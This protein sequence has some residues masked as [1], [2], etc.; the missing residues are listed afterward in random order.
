[1]PVRRR[2]SQPQDRFTTVT[3]DPLAQL[4]PRRIT[5]RVLGCSIP[6]VMRLERAGLLEVVK[7]DP[8]TPNSMTYHKRAQ[9][10]RLARGAAA[11]AD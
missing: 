11:D 7:L 1:M 6:T 9:V 10:E 5:A 4:L 3:L 2:I 8:G